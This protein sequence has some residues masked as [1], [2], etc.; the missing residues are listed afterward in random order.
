MFIPAKG[1]IFNTLLMFTKK[2]YHAGILFCCLLAVLTIHCSS[3][4]DEQT[5]SIELVSAQPA[6][7]TKASNQA[8]THRA[9]ND[10]SSFDI[11]Y[12]MGRFDP[13]KHPDFVR[14][15]PAL[16]SRSDMYLRKDAYEAF[17]RMHKAAAADGVKLLIISA[18][19][20]FNY[21]KGIWQAKWL[22]ER[23]VDGQNLAE[24]M[25]DPSSR[26]L[27]I[28]EFSSMPGSSRHHWGTDIDLNELQDKFFTTN[29]EG[30]KIYAWLRAHAAEYGFC[31]PYSAGRPHGYHEEKWHWSYLPIALQLTRL[32]KEQ[33][34]DDMI[35][36]F[37]GAETAK[38][39][40]IVQ[41]YVLGINE[42]CL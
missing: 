30:Q 9:A 22:G 8:N 37:S 28:L 32:A 31:Q 34:R 7:A 18:T 39:I 38:N 26:A 36:G 10:T 35:Q 5:P 23:L 42:E 27:K 21:Q 19:R 2:Q 40:G 24:T 12:L 25:P 6:P 15:D 3:K 4:Q 20:N 33:M 14:I 29:G 17:R 16:A 41:K 11:Q 1:R 13:A